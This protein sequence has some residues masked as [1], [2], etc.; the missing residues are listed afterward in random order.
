MTFI[1]VGTTLKQGSILGPGGK[2]VLNLRIGEEFYRLLPQVHPKLAKKVGM[3]GYR[4]GRLVIS[5][6][7]PATSQ[8]IF[9]HS[10]WIG[11]A[12]NQKIGKKVVRKIAFR[13][14]SS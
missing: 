5:T 9:L 6:P 1:S 12:L 8:E 7:S 4:E 10:R 3:Y 14:S 13:I 11:N 2:T